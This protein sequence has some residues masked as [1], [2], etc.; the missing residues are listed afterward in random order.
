ML[1]NFDS[2][3]SLFLIYDNSTKM[4]DKLNKRARNNLILFILNCIFVFVIGLFSNVLDTHYVYYT[5]LSA[6]ILVSILTVKND[7]N[8]YVIVPV[9]VVI[10]TW[11]S[12]MLDLTY[13]SLIA[14]WIASA[15]FFWVVILLVFRVA[16]TEKVSLLVFLESINVYLLLGIAASMMF[17]GVYTFNHDAYNPPGNILTDMSDFIYYAFVTMTTLGYGDITPRSTVARSIS[18]FFS[19]AGQLYLTMII[20]MLVGKYLNQPSDSSEDDND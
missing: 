17:Q 6:I 20:A 1:K 14:G 16:N 4:T 19:V 3:E 5:F 9:I 18:I 10:L 13:F 2:Q 15:F 7:K 8:K 12:E 11:V